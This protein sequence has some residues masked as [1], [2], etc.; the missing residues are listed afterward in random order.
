MLKQTRDERVCQI[1][2]RKIRALCLFKEEFHKVQYSTVGT[3]M[4][5]MEILESKF[6]EASRI[7]SPNVQ[8][9]RIGLSDH[10]TEEATQRTSIRRC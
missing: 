4:E 8:N 1:Y 10:P 7:F 6:L 5:I 2:L 9:R 3:S